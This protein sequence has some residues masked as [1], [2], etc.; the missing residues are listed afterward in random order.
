MNQTNANT[1][2]IPH[3][4][5]TLGQKEIEKVAA[6]IGSS[7]IAQGEAVHQFEQSFAAK[8]GVGYAACTSSGTAALHLVLLAMGVGAQDEVII[9]SYVCSALLNAVNYVGAVPVL[10][11]IVPETY[12]L[13]PA[14]VKKHLS[15]RTKA[16]IVPHLFGLASDLEGLLALNVPIIEDCAQ[17]AGS[18][19]RQKQVGTFG[20]AAIYSFYATKMMTTGEGGMV[21]SGSKALIDRVKA[22][23]EYDNRDR[24]EICYNYKMT[25]IQAAVGLA[26]L[27]RIDNFIRRRRSIAQLYDRAFD[28]LGFQLP[29]PDQGHIYYRYVIG[30]KTDAAPWIRTLGK[31]GIG[32]A[33]P[34]FLPLHM[35]MKLNGYPRST[36]AWKQALSIPIYPSL[37]SKDTDYIIENIKETFRRINND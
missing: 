32:C 29:L 7:Q 31:R 17:A 10:A 33:R 34:V 24:Y 18:T 8:L 20:T 25:D 26:Q 2:F 3:S 30:L 23:R 35:Y 11:D 13:D 6:V 37:A 9:P 5:P 21:V 22:L 12:N 1:D 36:R 27:S 15:R 14:D 4:R 16:V 19:H 28:A